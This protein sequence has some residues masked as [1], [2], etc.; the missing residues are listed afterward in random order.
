MKLS[1]KS[2]PAL[3]LADKGKWEASHKKAHQI[4]MS[5]LPYLDKNSDEYRIGWV[6]Y[7]LSCNGVMLNKPIYFLS[8]SFTNAAEQNEKKLAELYNNNPNVRNDAYEDCI[9]V[10]K[11]GYIH[12][13][14]TM[15]DNTILFITLQ[16]NGATVHCGVYHKE[17]DNFSVL[18]ST[19][20]PEILP[21]FNGFREIILFK[22]YAS[23]ELDIIEAGKK[24]EVK[25]VEREKVINE[26]G[27]DVIMLDSSWFREIIRKEGFKVRGHFRLQPYKNEKGEWTR[28]IIYIE[29]FEKHGYHR[30]AKISVDKETI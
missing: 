22:K 18:F 30:K 6:E 2:Y 5:Q 1:Y 3:V 17:K 7:Q 4:I 8:D 28:K 13:M 24:K 29:E 14:H 21:S 10:N 20:T 27:I 19:K 16:K 12:I 26:M 15:E 25:N 9:I 23:V 11:Y